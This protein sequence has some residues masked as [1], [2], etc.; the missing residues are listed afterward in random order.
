MTRRAYDLPTETEI[1]R[2]YRAGLTTYELAERFGGSHRSIAN[3]LERNS[4]RRRNGG[5]A[6]GWFGTAEQKAEVLR[7]Y[8]TGMSVPAVARAMKTRTAPIS[9]VLAEAEVTR[10]GGRSKQKFRDEECLEIAQEYRAGSDLAKLAR[11]YACSVPTIALALER[12]GARA[13]GGGRPKFWTQERERFVL[14]RYLVDGLSQAAI[15]EEMGFTQS[16]IS[17]VLIRNGVTLPTRSGSEHHSWAGG[18]HLDAKGY[19][20]VKVQG[21]DLLYCAP[22]YNGYILE[23][24][25]VMG[26]ALGRPLTRY[27]TVHHINGDHA[28]NRLENLQLRFGKHGKGVALECADCGSHNVQPVPLAG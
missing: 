16:V 13:R 10:P 2:L 27:E 18:R 3:A 23:H 28:D 1:I 24:R 7:L 26:R 6:A 21:D 19:V 12:A 15:G 20:H 9:A 25:L 4:V 8:A 11:K 17:K 5:K 14:G 22:F